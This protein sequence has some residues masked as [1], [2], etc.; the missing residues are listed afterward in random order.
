MRRV[1]FALLVVGLMAAFF[2]SR[3]RVGGP[4]AVVFDLAD[5]L[6]FAARAS[7]REVIM[8]GW[9]DAEPHLVSG[10]GGDPEMRGR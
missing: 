9:P 4:R 5:R 10:F 1:L 3:S 8:F 7:D 6:T 2:W